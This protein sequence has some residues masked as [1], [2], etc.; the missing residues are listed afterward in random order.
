MIFIPG[1]C[2]TANAASPLLSEISR[3]GFRISASERRMLF[4]NVR[5]ITRWVH[6]EV[7]FLRTAGQ[8][9]ILIG[10]SMGGDIAQRVAANM[11]VRAIL[12]STPRMAQD[13]FFSALHLLL[14]GRLACRRNTP[15]PYVS[16]YSE[17]FSFHIPQPEEEGHIV[18]RGIYSHFAVNNPQVIQVL[19]NRANEIRGCAHRGEPKQE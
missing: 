19:V 1:F 14:E 9:P 6:E 17:A 7:A 5:G 10:Y 11:K 3:A 4:R 8:E 18:T 12:L 13:T 16:S 2:M 15:S